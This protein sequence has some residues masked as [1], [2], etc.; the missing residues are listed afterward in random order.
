MSSFQ[1]R[2]HRGA[3]TLFMD[4]KP[5]FCAIHL[6]NYNLGE[7]DSPA[8]L[9]AAQRLE[10]FYRQAGLRF[11]SLS[12]E[13][14]I[15][16]DRAYDAPTGGFPARAFE[17]LDNLR[18]LAERAPE[19]KFLLRVGTEPRGDE[20]AWIQQHRQEC[21]V[22]E[23]RAKGIYATPSYASRLW[24][25]DAGRYLQSLIGYIFDRGLDQHI[26]GYLI[27]AGD[28]AEWVKVGPMED[29]AADYSPPMQA[30]FR[31]WL[32]EKYTDVK[33][34]RGAW[35]DDT[36]DFAMDLVPSPEEQADADLFLFKDPRRRRRAID[37]FQCLAHIVARDIDSLCGVAKQACRRQ[38]LAGVFYGYLQEMVW[39]NG[40]FGQRLADADVA[41]S[42]AARSGHAGLREVLA[43]PHVDFLSSPYSYG[44]RGVGGEGGFMSLQ[45]SVQRAGKLWLSEE[46]MRTH[47]APPDSFYGQTHTPSET[48]QVLKRQFAN[49]VAHA[50]GGWWCDFGKP[51]E[52]EVME[53]FRRSLQ[54]GDHQLGLEALGSAAEVAIVVDAESSFYRSTLNNFD[55]PNWR[56]RAWGI[57]R[58]GAPADFVLLSDV[59][60]GR[61]PEYKLYFFMNTFHLSAADRETL[62]RALR[63][64]GK[65]ALWVYAP[66]FVGDEGLSVE[67]CNEL[68]GLRLRMTPRQWGVSI[69]LSNFEHAITRPL[70]T[71]TFWG[72]D[73]RLGPLFT[74]QD[75]EA[76]TLGTAVINQ[77]RCEPGFVLKEGP[78]GEWAS[79]YS[80]APNIPPGVLREVARYAQVH[81]FSESEDV[82]YANHSYVALH[83]VRG[84]VKTVHLPHRADVWE[85]YSNRQVGRHC[86]SFQDQMAAGS[87]HLY[88]YG[89]APRP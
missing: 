51:A 19:G 46:D 53:V 52:P 60:S 87:T 15:S 62:R 8:S 35:A 45:A 18:R 50:A 84:E 20:S 25:Q 48:C 73:M 1:V 63:R 23:S 77:G 54:V 13:G 43:S 86:T 65:V 39:N 32:E 11:F 83:T 64:D 40:F 31:Q 74:V 89:A 14:C 37:H 82:L 71:S 80:A 21:E 79:L 58:L 68:M 75:P 28:S 72:T 36:V 4:G 85:V 76:V 49:V 38:H 88:Y 55:I 10:E 66:G 24:I 78:G 34:L 17:P 81:L 27:C 41:H 6:N 26:L 57:A 22:M 67:Q 56:N 2:I 9:A 5:A 59:L 16:F 30:A 47:Y 12:I 70:P 69:Y 7:P 29:W 33:A 42:A 61:A 44:F 3:P